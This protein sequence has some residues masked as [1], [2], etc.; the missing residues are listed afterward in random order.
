MQGSDM[1]VHH[2]ERG[3]TRVRYSFEERRRAVRAMLGGASAR[4][5][6]ASVGADHT[7]ASR[8]LARYRADGWAG[9][10][11][12]RAAPGRRALVEAIASYRAE[13]GYPPSIRDL[14][15]AARFSSTSV[16]AYR[17]RECER[18]GLIEREARLSRAITLTA[19]G[20]ALAGL[21]PE[22]EPAS[23]NAARPGRAA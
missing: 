7:S 23:A 22:R 3:P 15:Q 19:A 9:L 8:W 14:Q 1:K 5:A 12:G 18:A 13:R 16:V 21:M 2:A 11:G 4:V 6:A 20:R 17:L 10:R